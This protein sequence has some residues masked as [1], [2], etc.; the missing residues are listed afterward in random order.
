MV[1]ESIHQEAVEILNML[2]PI[3]LLKMHKANPDNTEKR[4]RKSC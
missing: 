4:N 2:Y 1:E 3:I